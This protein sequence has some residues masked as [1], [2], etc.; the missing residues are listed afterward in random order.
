MNSR[1]QE[2]PGA[3]P[4]ALYCIHPNSSCSI[5]CMN[6]QCR[7]EN[8]QLALNTT[9]ASV[10]LLLYLQSSSLFL[11]SKLYPQLW[12]CISKVVSY[13]IH[14]NTLTLKH[15]L[16]LSRIVLQT[17]EDVQ[18]QSNKPSLISSEEMSLVLTLL[19]NRCQAMWAV[20]WGSIWKQRNSHPYQI[21]IAKTIM[22]ETQV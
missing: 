17:S 19:D 10:S 22:V 14:V 1:S 5:F 12:I 2:S 6:T 20:C 8:S 9:F 3:M 21:S 11:P 16:Y 15:I 13:L 18:V 7:L 4:E